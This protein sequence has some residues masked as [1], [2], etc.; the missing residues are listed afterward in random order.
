MKNDLNLAP[1]KLHEP[2]RKGGI[3]EWLGE[4]G[5]LAQFLIKIVVRLTPA[6]ITFLERL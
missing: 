3:Y 1:R 6:E 4:T 5:N 2:V